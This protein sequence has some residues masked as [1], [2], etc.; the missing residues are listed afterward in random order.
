M[1]VG[2]F[3]LSVHVPV[4]EL[5]GRVIWNPQPPR[6]TTWTQASVSRSWN[7]SLFELPV[8]RHPVSRFLEPYQDREPRRDW[9]VALAREDARFVTNPAV[10]RASRGT[11]SVAFPLTSS[12]RRGSSSNLHMLSSQ[13]IL[14]RRSLE[15]P[16]RGTT[17]RPSSFPSEAGEVR[18]RRS[19]DGG[20]YSTDVRSGALA[21]M[22]PES[23][24]SAFRGRSGA[25]DRRPGWAC[26]ARRSGGEHA[27]SHWDENAAQLGGTI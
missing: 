6:P 22:A 27:Q 9:D 25:V 11:V 4:G 24:L 3:A 20:S 8:P 17:I 19:P 15:V 16:R 18:P 13:A 26:A 5:V 12:K 7:R 1:H 10:R 2:N 23:A 21:D 14:P